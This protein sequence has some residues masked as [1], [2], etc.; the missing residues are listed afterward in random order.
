[1]SCEFVDYKALFIPMF[2]FFNLNLIVNYLEYRQEIRGPFS[3]LA[4]KVKRKLY[5]DSF[6]LLV[7]V[8]DLVFSFGFIFGVKV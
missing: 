3:S 5:R 8:C 4:V 2:I 1:M 7:L 6:I